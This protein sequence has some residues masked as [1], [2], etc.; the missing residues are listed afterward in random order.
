MTTATT[1][2]STDIGT[3]RCILVR[4]QLLGHKA[5]F[6]ERT[7]AVVQ[8]AVVDLIDIGK[9]VLGM[10][11]G[12]FVVDSDFIVEDGVEADVLEAGNLLYISE[13]VAVALAQSH[14]GA[15]GAEHL[16]PEVGEGVSGGGGVDLNHIGARCSRGGLCKQARHPHRE[17]DGEPK[18]S[19]SVRG[20]HIN[21][22]SGGERRGAV[23]LRSPPQ[24]K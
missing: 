9:V 14:D 12:V 23:N 13:I 16:L 19:D 4:R 10:S 5:Q 18:K 22:V 17:D 8:Q 3:R 7:H 21:S 20:V 1:E 11:L 24:A 2:T 15:L 6:D